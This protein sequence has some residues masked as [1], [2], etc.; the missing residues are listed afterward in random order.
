MMAASRFV[1][2]AKR[3]PLGM[4]LTLLTTSRPSPG[5]TSAAEHL[6][7]ALL[8]AFQSGRDNA[9]GN[10]PGLQEP[11]VIPGKI[12]HLG[13]RGDVGRR[14]QINAQRSRSTGSSITRR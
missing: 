5:P 9:G 6:D 12:E 1:E 13:Q 4:P 2:T 7:K 8:R 10:D 3:E 14:F 11:Q